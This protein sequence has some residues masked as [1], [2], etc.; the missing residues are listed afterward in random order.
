MLVDMMSWVMEIHKKSIR[1]SKA[2]A[3]GIKS[4]LREEFTEMELHFS[5]GLER[6]ITVPES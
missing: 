6:S 3:V 1:Y 2:L 5:F 4:S